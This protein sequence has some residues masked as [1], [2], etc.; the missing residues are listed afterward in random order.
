[1][2]Y[3]TNNLDVFLDLDVE[4]GTGCALINGTFID[5][6]QAKELLETQQWRSCVI[7][8]RIAK[9][10]SKLLGRDIPL[11][12]GNQYVVQE[13]DM[14][15]GYIEYPFD[16]NIEDVIKPEIL[17]LLPRFEVIDVICNKRTVAAQAN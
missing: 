16:E 7:G 9:K 2:I 6:S 15:I 11:Y 10:I 14:I 8:K 3:L 5:V 13:G 4:L 17:S 1:M 12:N